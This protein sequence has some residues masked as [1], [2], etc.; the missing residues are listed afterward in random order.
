MSSL[1]H[2]QSVSRSVLRLFSAV[3][4]AGLVT[5]GGGC[6]RQ[7]PHKFGQQEAAIVMVGALSME[8]MFRAQAVRPPVSYRDDAAEYL[9]KA[10][11]SEVRARSLT[12]MLTQPTQ[13]GLEQR[14]Q[15]WNALNSS[16]TKEARRVCPIGRSLF[17][18]GVSLHFVHLTLEQCRLDPQDSALKLNTVRA[19]FGSPLA[20]GLFTGGRELPLP[21]KMCKLVRATQMA[22]TLTEEGR[23]ACANRVLM[24]VRMTKAVALRGA[25]S[26]SQFPSE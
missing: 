14:M 3:A 4:L 6:R 19:V 25:D 21:E 12:T 10:G 26:L 20:E 22:D 11:F 24:L 1:Y 8:A 16:L 13:G 18:F 9:K 15:A 7:S 2:L 5:V 17:N 23:N